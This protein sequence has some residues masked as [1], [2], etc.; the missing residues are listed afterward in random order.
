MKTLGIIGF[1]NMGLCLVEKVKTKKIKIWIFDKDKTKIG[2]PR[3]IYVAKNNVDLVKRVEAVVLA[4]KPQDFESVLEEIK[5]VARGKLIISI[6]AG[7]T[8]GY[9]E[10]HLGEARIIRTMPNMPARIGEAITCICKGRFATDED[11]DFTK[12]L[13]SSLGEILMLGEERMDAA[14]AISGSGPGYCYDLMESQCIDINSPHAMDEFKKGFTLL[15]ASA[16]VSVGFSPQYAMALA[17]ATASG[18]I[19]LL[20]KSKLPPEEFKKQIASKG[21][22]TEAG[23]EVLHRGGSLEEAAKAALNRAKE[24]SKN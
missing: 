13:F 23:L 14:T 18:S 11:V 1:G 20:I 24:L 12:D 17:R 2:K 9:I 10:K 4:V 19:N 21:G 3:G 8:T 6:A 16:A 5:T 7:I 22:T 15:L